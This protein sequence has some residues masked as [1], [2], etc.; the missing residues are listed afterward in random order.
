MRQPLL[1]LLLLLVT[2]PWLYA[3]SSDTLRDSPRDADVVHQIWVG[4]KPAGAIKESYAASVVDLTHALTNATGRPWR[5]RRWSNQDMNP[6]YFPRTYEL[7][8]GIVRL[9][10]P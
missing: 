9:G 3:S 7:L 1:L 4:A 8:H 6:R 10:L 2:S 5:Y